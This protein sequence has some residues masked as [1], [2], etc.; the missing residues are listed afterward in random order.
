MFVRAPRGRPPLLAGMIGGEAMRQRGVGRWRRAWSVAIAVV[1]ASSFSPARAMGVAP[2]GPPP[3]PEIDGA[4]NIAVQDICPGR[5]V[6]H[7]QSL[8]D[9]VFAAVFVDA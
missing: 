2:P 9:T 5:V 1:S 4:T 8:F 3:E 7:G 6:D